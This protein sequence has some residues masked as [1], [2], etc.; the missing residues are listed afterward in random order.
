MSI[1]RSV[2]QV[3]AFTLLENNSTT[4]T[5]DINVKDISITNT[6]ATDVEIQLIILPSV[7]TGHKLIETTIPGKV[8]LLYDTAFSFPHDSI[9]KIIPSNT[10]SLHITIN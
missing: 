1:F 2:A 5:F 9:L 10:N 3:S 4:N 8:T 7:G 6:D